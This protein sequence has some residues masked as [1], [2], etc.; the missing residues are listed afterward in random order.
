M[1]IAAFTQGKFLKSLQRLRDPRLIALKLVYTIPGYQDAD[2]ETK[3]FIYDAVSA[4]VVQ[5]TDKEV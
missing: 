2:L 5:S 1:M 3:N 4:K